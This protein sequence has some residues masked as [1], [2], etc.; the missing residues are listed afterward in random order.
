MLEHPP[1]KHEPTRGGLATVRDSR[2]AENLIWGKFQ[3]E[4]LW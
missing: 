2:G 3:I 1:E 4:E